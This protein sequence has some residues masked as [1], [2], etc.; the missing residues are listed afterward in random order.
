[1]GITPSNNNI[2][3]EEQYRSGVLQQATPEFTV[4]AC[5][6]GKMN[7]IGVPLA[8]LLVLS[9]ISSL[10]PAISHCSAIVHR[11]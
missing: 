6:D 1:M 2:V 8:L 7:S 3:V 4:D 10:I 9:V 11:K 5:A